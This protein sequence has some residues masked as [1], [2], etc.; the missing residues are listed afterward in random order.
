V[1]RAVVPLALLLVVSSAGAAFAVWTKSAPIGSNS[2]STKAD[3]EAPTASSS[4]IAKSVGYSSGYIKQGATYYVY[5]N[6]ADG[7]NPASGVSTAT[8][9]VSSIDSG[10]TAVALASGSF[11]VGGVS[12]NRRTASL[13]ANA[14]ITAGTYSYT[15]SMSDVAGNARVQTGFSVVIDNTVPSATDI[16]TANGAG[17]TNGLAQIG[18]TITYTYSEP[19]D[20][21][22]ILAGWTGASQNVVVRLN[23][24]TGNDSVTIFNSTNTTQLPFGTVSMNRSDYTSTS[25]TFGATGT[26]STMVMAG[27]AITFT[28]GTQSGAATTAA[29]TG[30]MSWT[31][32]AT[33]QDRAGNACSTTARTETGTADK[34]F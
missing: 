11:S 5:A 34:D 13:T 8:V 17:G 27:N 6:I 20:P 9:D 1:R 16:Q 25:R 19:I 29:G 4:V 15:I 30:N 12:Y 22:S 10:Q 3:W 26:P 21:N 14:S 33:A 18:D 7:G 2:F 32:S 31:P 24:V 28:L 23:Q